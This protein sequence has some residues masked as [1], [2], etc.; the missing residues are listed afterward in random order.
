[1]DR[2]RIGCSMSRNWAAAILVGGI[3][4]TIGLPVE[5]AG[6]TGAD[7]KGDV[8]IKLV[9]CCKTTYFGPAVEAWN[10]SHPHVKVEQEVIPFAQLN[11]ILESRL[12]TRDT[13]FD[14]FILDPPRTAAFA[15]KHYALD[16]TPYLQKDAQGTLNPESV[17]ATSFEG[18][19]YAAPVFNSTQILIY[20]RSLLAQAGVAAPSID[21]DKRTTWEQVV[22][23]AEQVKQKTGT[24]TG[25]VFSQGQGYYQLQPIIM[26]AGG[27]PGLAGPENLTPEVNTAPWKKAMT[28]FGDLFRNGLS[29]RGVPFTQMD[30]IFTSGKSPFIATSSDRVREFENQKLNFGVAAFP[31]FAD[32]KA[33][34]ACDSFA[35]ALNPYSK[36]QTQAL[37]FVKWVALTKEGGE[38]AAAQ[39]PNVPANLLVRDRISNE[40]EKAGSGLEGL[41]KLI[42][43]ETSTTCAHRPQSVGFI[44]FETAF[45]QADADVVSGTPASAAL[46]KMQ[47]QLEADFERLR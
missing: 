32:G 12:R 5:A 8:T 22:K 9:S 24:P 38:A 30:P 39:S 44:Q 36:L 27:G 4:A 1:M 45:N 17:V 13:T 40:M 2:A 16:L 14:V 19:I 29:P 31:K 28:W 42:S 34:T 41:T 15:T 46:D 35:L 37:E 21:P 26:S 11:D 3:V 6:L 7:T 18:K 33:Y 43:Y 47:T 25:I 20:N 10:A 23:D